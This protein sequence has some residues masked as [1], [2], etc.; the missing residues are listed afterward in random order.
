[1]QTSKT[2]QGSLREVKNV[3]RFC[4]P[5]YF[6]IWEA[7]LWLMWHLDLI[8]A[9]VV[10]ALLP[11]CSSD[12]QCWRIPS[13]LVNLQSKPSFVCVPGLYEVVR[14]CARCVRAVMHQQGLIP[15]QRGTVFPSLGTGQAASHAEGSK[16][17]K[18]GDVLWMNIYRNEYL[19]S[20]YWPFNAKHSVIDA[21]VECWILIFQS[22]IQ[23]IIIVW[24]LKNK[25]ILKSSSNW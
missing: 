12:P 21:N 23:I 10:W 3:F 13:K 15:A 2:Y 1:M 17:S 6:H 14:W 20:Y 24:D 16:L 7:H 19:N 25:C 22:K 5:H 4:P 9:E 8:K 18:A 11:S